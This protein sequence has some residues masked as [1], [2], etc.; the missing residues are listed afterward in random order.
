MIRIHN[1][2]TTA[3][4]YDATQCDP[5]VKK[6]DILIIESERDIGIADT[7]PVAVTR[8]H[9]AL[10]WILK[11]RAGLCSEIEDIAGGREYEKKFRPVENPE[12]I[13]LAVEIALGMSRIW[14]W[15]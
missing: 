15:W 4:A 7:W 9:G 10:H 8:E 11:G 5:E 3:D 13:F 14:G 2:E 6:G 12:E 1:F